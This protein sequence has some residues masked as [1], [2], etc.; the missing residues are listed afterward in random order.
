MVGSRN[1][2]FLPA[3]GYYGRGATMQRETDPGPAS[4]PLGF[5]TEM[6]NRKDLPRFK[7]LPGRDVRVSGMV[8]LRPKGGLPLILE[9]R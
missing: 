2:P 4:Q 8:T 7:P 6:A 9:Q 5:R 1:V 3:T